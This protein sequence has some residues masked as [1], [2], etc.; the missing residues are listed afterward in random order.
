[1]LSLAEG[2]PFRAGNTRRIALLAVVAAAASFSSHLPRLTAAN[3]VLD[4]VGRTGSDLQL[5]SPDYDPSIGGFLI[6][7]GLLVVAEAFRR[8]STLADETE[9][10]V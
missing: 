10:L 7:L 3:F 8:G 5:T 1:M 9:G 2:E 4:R 6:P